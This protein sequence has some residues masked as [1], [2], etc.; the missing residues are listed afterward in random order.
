M[1]MWQIPPAALCRKHLLGEHVEMHMFAGS[2]VK[3]ISMKGYIENGLLDLP[4]LKRRHDELVDE[5]T[6][7]GYN[8]KTPLEHEFIKDHLFDHAQK[9]DFE[10]NVRDLSSRCPECLQGLKVIGIITQCPVCDSIEI[11]NHGRHIMDNIC[12]K[13]ESEV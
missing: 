4:N 7:R 10:F 12:D 3:G 8:H 5:M 13:C 6:K 11:T 1:R 2:L 9:P